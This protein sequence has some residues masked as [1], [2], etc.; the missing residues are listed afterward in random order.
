[1]GDYLV[2]ICFQTNIARTQVRRIML[3]VFQDIMFAETPVSSFIRSVVPLIFTTEKTCR[4]VFE[5][6]VFNVRA[7]KKNSFSLLPW[8]T[9]SFRFWSTI[10]RWLLKWFGPPHFKLD[11]PSWALVSGMRG[12][13]SPATLPSTAVS[14]S[15]TP[16]ARLLTTCWSLVCVKAICVE[17]IYLLLFHPRSTFYTY[18]LLMCQFGR[19]RNI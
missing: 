10:L 19:W 12:T 2:T 6:G 16:R 4:T 18:I 14:C 5:G 3:T 9:I 1:M 13:A 11:S 8:L 17:C 7:I 15:S